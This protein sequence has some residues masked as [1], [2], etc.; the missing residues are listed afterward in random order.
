MKYYAVE[1]WTMKGLHTLVPARA[2]TPHHARGIVEK[3]TNVDRIGKWA[4]VSEKEYNLLVEED[5]K[6]NAYANNR[7]YKTSHDRDRNRRRNRK[8]GKGKPK[9]ESGAISN[10][11][12]ETP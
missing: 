2:H 9:L 8:D 10:G 11:D 3:R 7:K 5:S 12:Q 4:E 1:V 6:T